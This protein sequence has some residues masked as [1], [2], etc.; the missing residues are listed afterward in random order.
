MLFFYVHLK[1]PDQSLSAR[2]IYIKWHLFPPD[3]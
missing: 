1:L 2:R 3:Y